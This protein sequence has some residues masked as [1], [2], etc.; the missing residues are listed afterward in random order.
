MPVY[1]MCSCKLDG[2]ALIH[3]AAMWGFVLCSVLFPLHISRLASKA[4]GVSVAQL[5]P[6]LVARFTLEVTGV[7]S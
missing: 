5:H 6:L 4:S 7:E 2:L 1:S 3:S